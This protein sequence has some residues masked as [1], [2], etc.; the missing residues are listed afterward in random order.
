MH[1]LET[2]LVFLQNYLVSL[3]GSSKVSIFVD[4]KGKKNVDEITEDERATHEMK[5]LL[6]LFGRSQTWDGIKLTSM[7]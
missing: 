6:F 2:V 7:L 1:K 5:V 4:R 3:Q